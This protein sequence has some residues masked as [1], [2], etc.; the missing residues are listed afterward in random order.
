MHYKQ[1][2]AAFIMGISIAGLGWTPVSAASP[3]PTPQTVID[4]SP[5]FQTPE[6][7]KAFL[8]KGNML[9]KVSDTNKAYIG[10]DVRKETAEHGQ[11]PYAV[12]I[13]CSDSRVPPEHIF[14]AGIGDLFVVRTAGN[15]VGDFELGSVEYA[16]GQLG[17]KLVVVMG[18]TQCGAVEAAMEGKAEG[19]IQDIVNDI[20][21]G[22]GNS[23]T[24]RESEILNVQH[25]IDRVKS[26]AIVQKLLQENKVAVVGALY[27]IDS[28]AVEFLDEQPQVTPE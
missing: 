28:G 17:V 20:K 24:L 11:K 16:V 3:Q 6:Q 19:H 26:S 14:S 4:Q 22:I 23:P 21:Q 8:K 5:V 15:V 2:L 7:V 18:H 1:S 25:S 9:F 13:S 10:E 12:I 27:H